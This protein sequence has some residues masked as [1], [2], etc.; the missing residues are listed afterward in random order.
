MTNGDRVRAM[1]DYDLAE[2]L[3]YVTNKCWGFGYRSALG[4]RFRGEEKCDEACPM[5]K[6][7][8][9][10]KFDNIEEWLSQEVQDD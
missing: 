3:S 1:S 2:F 9:D 10:Q 5:Y 7:C 6:C 8:N 4:K